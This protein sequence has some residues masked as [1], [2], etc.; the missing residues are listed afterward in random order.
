MNTLIDIQENE[1]FELSPELLNALLKDHTLSTDTEQINIFWATDNY[2]ENDRFGINNP[3]VRTVWI[4]NLRIENSIAAKPSV[5]YE[6][7]LLIASYSHV[8]HCYT[9][10]LITTMLSLGKNHC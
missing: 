4:V 10:L 8:K 2:A 5:I 9:P 1:I 6:V 7:V 3:R